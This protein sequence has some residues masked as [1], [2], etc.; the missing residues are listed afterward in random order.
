MEWGKKL[1]EIVL[2]MGV[3]STRMGKILNDFKLKNGPAGAG[4][5]GLSNNTKFGAKMYMDIR[6]TGY[7]FMPE[8]TELRT[9]VTGSLWLTR[10][11]TSGFVPARGRGRLG[12]FAKEFHRADSSCDNGSRL[13]MPTDHD[14]GMATGHASRARPP[15]PFFGGVRAAGP[16]EM[17]FRQFR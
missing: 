6:P 16:A 8:A 9:G 10:T 2:D 13:N 17:N 7:S 1:L 14:T 15:A 5:A 3:E 11:R 12:T 4:P